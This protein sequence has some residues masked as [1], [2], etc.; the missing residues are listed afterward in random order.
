[1]RV[2]APLCT[3]WDHILESEVPL[4]YKLVGVKV[5]SRGAGL[6]HLHRL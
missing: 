3:A 5:L 4:N 1:M 2:D 6:L